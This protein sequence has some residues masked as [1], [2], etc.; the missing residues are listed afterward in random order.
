MVIY[1]FFYSAK[2]A[3]D[4]AV[5][6]AVFFADFVDKSHDDTEAATDETNHNFSCQSITF[7]SMMRALADMGLRL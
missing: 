4:F 3:V 5:V 7:S 2:C 1:L 6:G